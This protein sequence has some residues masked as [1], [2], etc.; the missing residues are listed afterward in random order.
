MNRKEIRA[1]FASK[2]INE[3]DASFSG[4]YPAHYAIVCDLFAFEATITG[5]QKTKA[6]GELLNC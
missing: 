4:R 1:A 3:I 2:A 5:D 6:V